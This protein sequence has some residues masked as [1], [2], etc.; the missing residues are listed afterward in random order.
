MHNNYRF[1][2]MG[3]TVL[4]P[5]L[6]V[7]ALAAQ[8][9]TVK[10]RNLPESGNTVQVLCA[11]GGTLIYEAEFDYAPGTTFLTKDIPLATATGYQ[12]RATVIKGLGKL[13][14]IVASGKVKNVDVGWGLNET[15]IE[16]G[17]PRAELVQGAPTQ[18]ARVVLFRYDDAAALLEIGDPATLW[19]TEKNL[20]IN[21]AGRQI[22]APIK[23]DSDGRLYAAFTVPN[24]ERA[25]FCQAGYYYQH[26]TAADQIPVFVHPDMTSGA[27]RLAVN[28]TSTFIQ[29][30]AA[31]PAANSQ[32]TP[33]VGPSPPKE[34]TISI[35]RA[36]K[37]GRLERVTTRS[38]Q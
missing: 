31:T 23:A 21:T 14:L 1:L 30:P 3:F 37:D 15:S 35:I 28:G 11:L 2:L 5:Y 19:C 24:T 27:S 12:L 4:S 9:L 26:L 25:T 36:G 18:G 10:V 20:K 13:P 34:R 7:N 29:A 17:T 22:I 32:G 38:K 6:F 33:S 16:L 8:S